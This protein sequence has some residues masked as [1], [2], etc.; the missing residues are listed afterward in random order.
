VAPS[1][2]NVAPTGAV[3]P[4]AFLE[5]EAPATVVGELLGTPLRVPRLEFLKFG[6]VF[7][8]GAS[9]GP[10][11]FSPEEDWPAEGGVFGLVWT[12]EEFKSC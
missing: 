6:L 11:L 5:I 10:E 2:T 8:E 3:S 9:N 1:N 7:E 4:R 12:P